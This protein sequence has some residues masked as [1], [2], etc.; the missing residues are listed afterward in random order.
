MYLRDYNNI[1]VW[2]SRD[3]FT[4]ETHLYTALWKIKYNIDI[5][6]S[7]EDTAKRLISLLG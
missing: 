7:K 2:F 4:D 3:N 5:C 1:I 6:D